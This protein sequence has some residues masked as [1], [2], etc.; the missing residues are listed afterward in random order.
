MQ[1]IQKLLLNPS[2]RLVLVMVVLGGTLGVLAPVD[3]AQSAVCP[4]RPV[5]KTYYNDKFHT[6]IVGQRGLDCNCNDI[7][8]GIT[9]GF[10]TSQIQCCPVATC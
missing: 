5:L 7:A 1:R 9:T 2:A 10:F 8:W 6:G 3:V 4:F